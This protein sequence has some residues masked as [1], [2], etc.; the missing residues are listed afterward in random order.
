M[1]QK[2][3]NAAFALFFFAWGIHTWCDGFKIPLFT[4]HI[5]WGSYL[6]Y[7][8]FIFFPVF[9]LFIVYK[10]GLGLANK[11]QKDYWGFIMFAI[12][13]FSIVAYAVLLKLNIFTMG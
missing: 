2:V 8:F 7:F 10:A 1:F 5:G 13:L 9:F 11:H 3:V 6:Y 12:A 4:R